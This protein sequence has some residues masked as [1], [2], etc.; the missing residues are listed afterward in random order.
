MQYVM[1][2]PPLI[3]SSKEMT[4]REAKMY[5]AWFVECIP[6]R[7]A[8]LEQAVRSSKVPRYQNWA[9][10]LLPESLDILGEWFSENI[11]IAPPSEEFKEKR[12]KSL[13]AIPA[14]YR[15]LAE[16]PEYVFVDVTYSFMIDLGMYLGETLR[17][18][19]PDLEWQLWTKNKKDA[20]YHKPVLIGFQHLT[21][22]EPQ[23]HVHVM[24]LKLVEK[25]CLPSCLRELFDSCVYRET[26]Q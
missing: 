18:R 13:D 21:E 15:P 10:D 24:A 12:L 5:F 23:S 1:V 26:E 8:I 4:R 7:I 14:R 22:Y 2:D 3:K 20:V 9:A 19:L 11:V 17:K 25:R 16:M 6:E